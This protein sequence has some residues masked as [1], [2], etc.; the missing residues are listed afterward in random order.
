MLMTTITAMIITAMIIT[1][2]I[3]I[4]SP[5]GIRDTRACAKV[6]RVEFRGLRIQKVAS[7]VSERMLI[8]SARVKARSIDRK[9]VKSLGLGCGRLRGRGGAELSSRALRAAVVLVVQEVEDLRG[10]GEAPISES[11]ERLL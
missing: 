1:A 9:E 10:E 8:G 3:I 5:R 11:S 2:M 6:P 4:A 7:D